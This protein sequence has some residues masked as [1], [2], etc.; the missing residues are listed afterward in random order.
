MYTN[1]EVYADITGYFTF[2]QANPGIEGAMNDYLSGTANDQFLSNLSRVVTGQ[3]A[4][5]AAVQLTIEANVQQAAWDALG[6]YS[7]AVVALDP[8]T[9]AILA[10]VSSPPTTRTPSRCTAASSSSPRTTPS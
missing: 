2:D 9:G 7:G 3:S 8:K 10:M 1:P 4:Q 5:G 6:D